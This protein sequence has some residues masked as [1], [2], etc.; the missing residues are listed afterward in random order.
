MLI[1]EKV[2][3]ILEEI[4]D[5]AY[6]VPGYMEEY[7]RKAIVTALARIHMQE[8]KEKDGE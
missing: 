2:N 5:K 8:E 6:M 1:G 7:Y 4:N 3:I